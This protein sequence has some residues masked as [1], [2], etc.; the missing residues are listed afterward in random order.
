[1]STGGHTMHSRLLTVLLTASSAMTLGAGG[2]NAKPV[3]VLHHKPLAPRP[4]VM[5]APMAEPVYAAAIT[6]PSGNVVVSI[7]RG[8][9]V[10]LPGAM[11]DL[12]VAD[13]KIADVQVKSNHQLYIYGRGSGETTIY[14][15]NAA[16]QVSWS[17]NVRVG[18]KID[19]VDQMLKVAMPESHISVATIGATT[20]LL[21]GTVAQPEDSAEAVKLVQGFLGKEANII[22]RIKTATPLQVNLHVRI[23][24]VSRTYLKSI[25]VNLETAVAN[26]S[27]TQ[28]VVG[29]GRQ[30]TSAYT[31]GASCLGAGNGITSA[32]C[33]A[34]QSL[35]GATTIGMA[36]KFLGLNLLGAL[37]AGETSG[38]VST[39]A[40]PNLTAL[41][42]ETAEFLAGGEYPY[43]S[44][45][46]LGAVSVEY[47]KYG[48]SLAYT[49]TV[50]ADGRI[51][52]RV[53]PEVS[54]IDTSHTL[55]MAGYTVYALTMRR[56]ET[57]VELGSGQSFMIAGLL[58]NS[59]KN[60]IT[61]MPGAGDVPVLGALFKSTS[62]QRGETELVIV[63]TP[64]LVKPVDAS[65]IRLPTD[66]LESP[67]EAQRILG[68]MMNDGKSGQRSLSPKL[69]DPPQGPAP[70][71]QP[72][73]SLSD[74]PATAPALAASDAPKA[75][76]ARRA[77]S[78]PAAVDATPGFSSN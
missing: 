74:E 32:T 37:D 73:V 71:G 4:L 19:S 46:G 63:V 65:E 36:T 1:M 6:H 49:P 77:A 42:G 66:G 27:T 55:T 75:K 58:N 31:P 5:R 34:V 64:Y 23:A 17:A 53:R 56:A 14:A 78:S 15:S 70:Q 45:S 60:A 44:S 57:T 28:V 62:Y 20:V 69:V 25:G 39:L 24:E 30:V 22:S 59:T 40:E 9:L 26:G 2:A 29:Q 50:L 33:N 67:N 51:S 68:N 35:A 54:D 12:F 8:Q 48:I 41:S 21:T 72:K 61:K 38:L 11:K 52:M 3:H 16:G 13:D 43:P 7:G 76:P 47:K 18:A 10:N